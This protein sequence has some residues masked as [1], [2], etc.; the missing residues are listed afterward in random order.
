[1][2]S[3]PTNTSHKTLSTT[4]PEDPQLPSHHGLNHPH[5]H[6]PYLSQS[7]EGA[8]AASK[9]LELAD[10]ASPLAADNDGTHERATRRL[11]S[12]ATRTPSPVDR[13]I[14]HEKA[15]NYSPRRRNNGPEFTVIRGGQKRSNVLVALA[16]FPNGLL[17]CPSYEILH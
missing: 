5:K 13:I 17:F 3:E 4:Y 14:E 6:T 7:G 15:T 1:M 9:S 8:D 11:N 10:A 16:D 12:I 2:Q